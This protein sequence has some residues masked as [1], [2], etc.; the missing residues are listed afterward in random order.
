M[1]AL[2]IKD[3]FANVMNQSISASWLI[4]AVIFVR[5]CMKKAPK[6]L[7]YVLWAL[8]AV[9]LLC[10]FSIESAWSLVP[11]IESFSQEKDEYVDSIVLK[12]NASAQQELL[13]QLD[14]N[15]QYFE[16]PG[17]MGADKNVEI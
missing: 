17:Q 5:I 9:R 3:L 16:V 14:G 12:E 10:P 4:L 8:V 2:W 1:I 6:S 13:E 11:E 7:R 15:A